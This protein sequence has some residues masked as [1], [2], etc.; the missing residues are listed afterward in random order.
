MQ[1]GESRFIKMNRR[2]RKIKRRNKIVK[3]RLQ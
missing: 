2:K 3:D 1:K